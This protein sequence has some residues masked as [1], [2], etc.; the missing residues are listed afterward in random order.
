MTQILGIKFSDHGPVCYFAS[1]AHVVS[2]G[3]SVLVETDQGLA[4]GHVALVAAPEAVHQDAH[5]VVVAPAENAPA[6]FESVLVGADWHDDAAA[7]AT[8]DQGLETPGNASEQA[9]D[10][11]AP[12]GGVYS[13]EQAAQY[14][15]RPLNAD[16]LQPIFR[17][18]GPQDLETGAENKRLARRAFN[19]CRGCISSQ[20]LDMKLVDVEVLHDRSKMIFYFTAPN[21]IDFRE[22][23]KSL[24]REFHTRIEL[25]QIGVRHETQMIG[26]IGNCGQVVCCRRFLRKFAPVTIKMAKEQNLFLNPAKISGICGRLLCCLSYEQKGYEEFHK[27]CPK[28]GKRIQTAIGNAKV[29]RANFFKKSISVWVE[30]MG[31]REFTLEEW[32]DLVN[33]QISPEGAA[34]APEGHAPERQGRQ[35]GGRPSTGRPSRP[36]RA[37]RPEK[38]D[39]PDRPEKSDRPEPRVQ[40]P[41]GA[42]TQAPQRA[43]GEALEPGADRPERPEGDAGR[44]RPRRKRRK[45]RGP[46]PA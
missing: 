22:L 33:R 23:I 14:Q 11:T 26:A 37:P 43:A 44:S 38:S 7:P 36:E 27:Q 32:K 29:L 31:E 1:G 16:G 9:H 40:A 4:L 24:V 6:P 8:P 20:N 45:G 39:R 34:Q 21:R 3:Q 5:V 30:D 13:L 28:I 10:A 35:G 2:A 42:E 46:K 12:S 19:F 15:P 17:L 41:D 25:R 18:A